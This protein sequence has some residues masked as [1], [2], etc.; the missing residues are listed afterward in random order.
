MRLAV[1]PGPQKVT[2]HLFGLL[3]CALT[4]NSNYS[5]FYYAAFIFFPL[6]APR[7]LQDDNRDPNGPW[8]KKDLLADTAT[9]PEEDR[10]QLEGTSVSEEDLEESDK[11]LSGEVIPQEPTVRL[12]SLMCCG[13]YSYR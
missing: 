5:W 4:L 3:N 1:P 10:Q 11:A 9:T 8:L 13:V 6:D 2:V 12:C 7:G